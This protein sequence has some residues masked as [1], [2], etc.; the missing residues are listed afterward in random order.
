[1]D[2]LTQRAWQKTLPVIDSIKQHPFNQQL[3]QG[4]LDSSIFTFYIEQDMLYLQQFA[5]CHALIAA[6]APSPYIRDFLS[7]AEQTFI[8]EQEV[9][10]QY[11]NDK[12]QPTDS[13]TTTM[14]TLSY[15]HYLLA[16]CAQQPVEVAMAAVL[17]CFW[18]YRE[19]GQSIVD[20]YH[21]DKNQQDNPYARWIETYSGEA[22]NEGVKR[23]LAIT[24][25]VA[26]NTTE[27]IRLQ[28]IDAFYK[29]TV[30]EWHFWNDAYRKNRFDQCK[31][32]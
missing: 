21:V 31:V 7:F 11:F 30:L 18:V 14:A 22:F 25:D 6:R 27:E 17:P 19:V 5:R 3:A 26:A 28:M 15:T 13:G 24:D 16:V 2:K 20:N 1:M 29:A 23:M 12:Y 10:H 32:V 8:V 4:T 9:V